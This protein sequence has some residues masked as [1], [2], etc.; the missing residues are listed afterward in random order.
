[1][2]GEFMQLLASLER[3][4]AA[5]ANA[6][7]KMVTSLINAKNERE[8]RSHQAQLNRQHQG[9]MKMMEFGLNEQKSL[10][11]EISETE[12]LLED[13]GVV[14]QE[15]QGLND[16]D[17]TEAGNSLLKLTYDKKVSDVQ[18]LKGKENTIVSRLNDIESENSTLEN[19]LS[20]LKSR[21]KEFENVNKA[22]VNFSEDLY[23]AESGQPLGDF[24]V[25][26]TEMAKFISANKTDFD[27]LVGQF[28][29][30]EE[31]RAEVEMRLR[32]KF[33]AYTKD[34]MEVL[35]KVYTVQIQKANVAKIN[36]ETASLG[37]GGQKAFKEMEKA[38][39]GQVKEFNANA[40]QLGQHSNYTA[41]DMENDPILRYY[42]GDTIQ[43]GSGITGADTYM[44]G[45]ET[46]M[47][48]VIT[49]LNK[50]E[51]QIPSQFQ[52]D[53]MAMAKWYGGE[54]A[55]FSKEWKKKNPDYTTPDFVDSQG[56]EYVNVLDPQNQINL[57]TNRIN[58]LDLK[59]WSMKQPDKVLFGAINFFKEYTG[60]H[61]AY[62]YVQDQQK[63]IEQSFN[64]PL[65]VNSRGLNHNTTR[66]DRTNKTLSNSKEEQDRIDEY[67]AID[68]FSKE[69]NINP[70]AVMKNAEEAG[71]TVK[72]YIDNYGKKVDPKSSM[73]DEEAKKLYYGGDDNI[74]AGTSKSA[75]RGMEIIKLLETINDKKES[76][77][78]R[79]L[80][81][82]GMEERQKIAKE[83]TAATG[84]MGA[85]W[86][87]LH[88][89][90]SDLIKELMAI[91]D[92]SEK[93]GALN[94]L[95]LWNFWL[96]GSLKGTFSE[97]SQFKTDWD[98]IDLARFPKKQPMGDT[99]ILEQMISQR[100]RKEAFDQLIGGSRI[101]D[102][103]ST[104]EQATVGNV[105]T[106]YNYTGYGS[107][108]L[109]QLISGEN[110]P[111]E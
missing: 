54:I 110:I 105:S 35:N 90:G 102:P 75:E 79:Y 25:D 30:G 14:I 5:E 103:A 111:K 78:T 91:R 83:R 22:L 36:A 88:Q 100:K 12:T 86:E 77:H 85:E 51:I 41:D 2:A 31:G 16:D 107:P 97:R 10:Q 94:D 19:R 108:S 21:V 34:Q 52:N 18:D 60:S 1:M 76:A 6:D 74:K 61:D 11:K 3:R 82:Q 92:L 13:L 27:T 101:K 53:P 73:S 93:A 45:L 23:D 47:A 49:E 59:D 7:A 81:Q 80:N 29:G 96:E 56:N 17:K 28:G 62:S 71:L 98:D 109:D 69:Q 48:G 67:E 9:N 58:D 38:W 66:F 42:Q 72:E 40:T 104:V 46:R 15:H 39:N 63:L 55:E 70:D 65:N 43:A 64:I 32:R 24:K 68:K 4:Q 26:D 50:N 8:A 87:N 37:P 57:A 84:S 95:D 106:Q 33:S 20:T 89:Q 44:G 99:T